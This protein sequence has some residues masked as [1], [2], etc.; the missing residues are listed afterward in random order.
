[1]KTWPSALIV[2]GSVVIFGCKTTKTLNPGSTIKADGASWDL[3][4][5]PSATYT[6][7][8]NACDHPLGAADL[9]ISKEECYLIVA[10]SAV[11][12]SSWNPN[13]SCEPWGNASDPCCGLTQ[14]RRMDAKAVGLTCNPHDFNPDGYTCNALTGLRNIGCKASNG[15]DCRQHGSDASLHTGVRK[16]LGY[17]TANLNSYIQDMKS[18]Y[19]RDDIRAKFGIKSGATRSWDSLF[20]GSLATRQQS[21]SQ[22]QSQPQQQPQQ[23][24]PQQEPQ[25]HTQQAP[26]NK[27]EASIPHCDGPNAS[28]LSGCA[29]TKTSGTVDPAVLGGDVWVD[30]YSQAK[31]P[32]C[33]T[34]NSDPDG[35]GW[36][37]E[38][39][40]SCKVRGR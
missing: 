13:K 20:Y 38:Q 17:N 6:A 10:G 29:P 34:N 16:H 33:T 31:F 11:R 19:Q 7:I 4:N 36:G 26:T 3:G 23:Q 22:V 18:V 14:S 37:W 25:Q 30:T 28:N 1:M 32:Y 9:G 12:E 15:Q 21:L 8:K 35:D 27:P 2:A 40:K 24:P 5:M 39:S